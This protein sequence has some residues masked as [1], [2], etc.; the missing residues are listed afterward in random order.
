MS[1]K[2][3]NVNSS[4]NEVK[5]AREQLWRMGSLE[6]KL[7]SHQ[8]EMYNFIHSKQDKIKVINCSRQI[9]KSVLLGVM[10]TEQ[11]IN[12]PNS[13]VKLLQPKQNMIRRN[14]KPIMNMILEDCPKDMYPE[15]KTQDNTFVFPNGSEIQLA[16]TDNGNADNIRGGKAHLCLIDE[17]GFCDDL[18]ELIS[19]ILIPTTLQTNGKIILCSTTSTDPNHDFHGQVDDARIKKTLMTLTI[20]DVLRIGKESNEKEPQIT[21]AKIHDIINGTPGGVDSDAFRTEYLCVD[22][23]T[24]VKTKA[25]YK[26]IKNINPGE[27][28]FTHL[29][30]YRTVKEVFKNNL[31]NR[32]VYK[33]RASNND[34]T[35]TEGH[36]LL[37]SIFNK[38]NLHIKTYWEKVENLKNIENWNNKIYLTSPI[39]NTNNGYEFIEDDLAYLCGWYV[40]EGHYSLK[41]Q[42]VIFSLSK[43]DPL[44]KIS[45]LCKKYFNKP[46]KTYKTDN[47]C[48][49]AH[50][51]SK[52]A[53]EFFMYFGK[54]ASKKSIPDFIKKAP[55]SAKKAFLTG[56]LEGDGYINEGRTGNT[57]NIVTSSPYLAAD[58]SDLFL[59]IG[60]SAGFKKSKR[61]DK[62]IIQGRLV[63]Q[64]DLYSVSISGNNYKKFC[65]LKEDSKTSRSKIYDN[66]FHSK[67]LTV[68]EIEYNKKIVYDIEVDEDHSYC[69][70]QVTYHNCE[71]ITDSDRSVFPEFTK[72]EQDIV[73]PW[74]RPPFCDKYVSMDIGFKDLTAVLFGY[75]DFIN[76]VLVIEDE[77][78]LKGSEMTT[79]RLADSI[80][81]KEHELWMNR[82]VGEQEKPYARVCDNNLIVIN[83]LAMLHQLYFRPTEKQNK[84]AAMNQLK[85]MIQNHQLVISPKCVNLIEHLKMATW[86]KTKKDYIRKNGHHFDFADSLIYMVRNLNTSHNPF[87]RGFKYEALG[88]R[89]SLFINDLIA[90][91]MENNSL[92]RFAERMA[93]KSSIR[94]KN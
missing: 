69:G 40:A 90:D 15:F 44:N 7:K 70:P 45:E 62:C 80:R 88:S 12:T 83:D 24:L 94:R 50:L 20:F 21:E 16:G 23:N 85:M 76:A 31:G 43:S 2:N 19:S 28:V 27:K 41:N 30:R 52:V 4:L 18:N 87:P 37:I 10:A 67:L 35:V 36:Q 3:S 25:G 26:E 17:A 6:W 72:H 93:P 39:E 81:E 89:N 5:K 46:L 86:D 47:S 38:Q 56:L 68:E 14:F 57:L 49:Q 55:N 66:Y 61:P 71:K 75:Y 32:K 92:Q 48:F 77:F 8:I 65:G 34:I 33:I 84:D 51:Y 79:E 29:G 22:E 59:S 64:K 63:N 1:K 73:V 9:G 42:S 54:G 74:V 60:I 91:E 82:L 53:K 13:I 58:C 11:C 78:A